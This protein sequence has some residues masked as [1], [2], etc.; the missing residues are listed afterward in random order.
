MDLAK[1][2]QRFPQLVT[3]GNIS[4]HTVHL[5]SREDVVREVTEA[6]D[7]GKQYGRTIVGISNALMPG[8]P[9]ENARAMIDTI[10]AL[11]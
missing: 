7:A 11:R 3:I 1:L 6:I 10:Q 5:G 4:S 8:T 9:I 2:H